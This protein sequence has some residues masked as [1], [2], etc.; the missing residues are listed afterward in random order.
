MSD[1]SA[2]AKTFVDDDMHDGALNRIALTVTRHEISFLVDVGLI[3]PRVEHEI[4][5]AIFCVKDDPMREQASRGGAI[6]HHNDGLTRRDGCVNQTERC[7]CAA[8]GNIAFDIDLRINLID[9]I[10]ADARADK[11]VRA[12]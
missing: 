3:R 7:I 2:G 6:H 9:R 10:P 5:A 11:T 1:P 4:V 8:A 12:L